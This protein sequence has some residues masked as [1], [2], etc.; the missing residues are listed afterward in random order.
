MKK[1]R[2]ILTMRLGLLAI[3]VGFMTMFISCQKEEVIPSQNENLVVNTIEAQTRAA[4]P[5]ASGQGTLSFEGIPIEGEKF[6]HFTFHAKEKNDGSVQGNGVLTYIGGVR[7][8]SFDIDCLTVDGNH[9]IM[10]GVIT[11]DDQFPENVGTL[12]WFEVFDNGEGANAN[13]DQ[14]SLF[15]SGTN[16]E[17]YDCVN[18]FSVD[19]YEIE[20][21]NIQVKN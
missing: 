1:I 2:K 18:D 11:G 6:R 4:G 15:Y 14:M 12:C 13:P 3:A 5:S 17:T 20:G 19:I 7:K 10:S 9:A 21:G 8:I 16:P